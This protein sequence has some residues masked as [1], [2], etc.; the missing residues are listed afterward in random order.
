VEWVRALPGL[1]A[2][3]R[4]ADLGA[5]TGLSARAFAAQGCRVV[6]VEPNP[7]M[8]AR[9]LRAAR[10]AAQ[11]GEVAWVR[12]EAAATGL[13][14]ASLDLVTAGQAFHWFEIAPTV[15]EI[16]RILRPGGWCAAFWNVRAGGSFMEEYDALLRELSA[17][18]ASV[19][20]HGPTLE[21]LGARSEVR[22]WR[23][24]EFPHVQRLDA[25]GL[26]GRAWSSSYVAHG[27]ADGEGFDRRLDE[28]FQR[29]A[30]G[31]R[32]E[33]AYRARAA[34]FRLSPPSP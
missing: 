26:R 20:R 19:P 24:A 5:G 8:L 16:A 21:A 2:R 34:A 9:A 22:D 4:V 3:P 29:H 14:T 28:L 10:G 11:T 6:G 30:R 12:A 23:E 7:D 18:Y 13:A 25:G 33:F 31:G 17:E 1:P 15:R 27:V 32:V